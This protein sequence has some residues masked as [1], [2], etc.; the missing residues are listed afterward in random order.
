MLPSEARIF[1]SQVSLD[2][3]L[4]HV[5]QTIIYFIKIQSQNIYFE[6]TLAFDN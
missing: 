1:F 6:N 5:L 3:S 4:Q 2:I